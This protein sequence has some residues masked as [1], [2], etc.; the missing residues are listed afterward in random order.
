MKCRTPLRSSRSS[1]QSMTVIRYSLV[2]PGSPSESCGSTQRRRRAP[3][4]SATETRRHREPPC[5]CVSVADYPRRALWVIILCDL[6][7]LCARSGRR[8]WISAGA[9]ASGLIV[10]SLLESRTSGPR[11]LRQNRIETAKQLGVPLCLRRRLLP[12][13]ADA[14]AG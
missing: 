5:L 9:A 3:R 11:D 10:E 13:E 1:S 6:A 12:E 4:E 7:K 8:A 14:A 2:G